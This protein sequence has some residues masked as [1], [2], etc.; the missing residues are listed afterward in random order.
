MKSSIFA[1][2][3]VVA[4]G[5]SI[6]GDGNMAWAGEPAVKVQGPDE[7]ARLLLEAADK[8]LKQAAQ[9]NLDKMSA[10]FYSAMWP[11]FLEFAL[12]IRAE[13]SSPDIDRFVANFKDL[14]GINGGGLML[15]ALVS[16][17]LAKIC[18][19]AS[20]DYDEAAD[21]VSKLA[22]GKEAP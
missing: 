20:K 13:N 15:V 21:C 12:F 11:V 16:P 7:K 2:A 14:Y 1:Y 10:A 9:K 6:P 4:L 5:I 3:V 17:K 18:F 8:E 22:K 19:P